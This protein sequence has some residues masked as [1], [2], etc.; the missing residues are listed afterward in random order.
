MA[1][2]GQT[3]ILLRTIVNYRR[4]KFYCTGPGNFLE[5]VIKWWIYLARSHIIVIHSLFTP[6]PWGLYY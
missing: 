1:C 4:K 6:G 3:P 2:H 5:V